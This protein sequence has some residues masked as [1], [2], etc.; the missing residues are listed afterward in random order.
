MVMPIN[1][2]ML[3]TIATGFISTSLRQRVVAHVITIAQQSNL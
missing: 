2:T 3:V 1:H